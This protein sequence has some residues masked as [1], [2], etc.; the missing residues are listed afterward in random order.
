MQGVERGP[1]TRRSP[2]PQHGSREV[3]GGTALQGHG[4]RETALNLTVEPLGTSNATSR[5]GADGG[6]GGRGPQR[7]QRQHTPRSHSRRPPG[8]AKQRHVS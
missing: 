3:T 6:R 1:D 2:E 5:A 8:S 4:E 7:A